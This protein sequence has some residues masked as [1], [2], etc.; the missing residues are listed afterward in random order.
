MVIPRQTGA[1]TAY[2]VSEIA[3]LTISNQQIDQLPLSP[4]RV[5][6]YGQYSKQL[7]MQA[8]IDVENFIRDDLLKVIAIDWD[9]LILNGSGAGSE[10]LGIM[11]TPGVGSLAFGAAA[12]YAN[13]VAF[14][15]FVATANADVGEMAYVTTPTAEGKL[16]SAAKLLT[17]A[18]TVA[19]TALWEG[20]FGS[21]SPDGIVAGFRAAST[22]QIPGNLMVFGVFS[23]VIHAMWG[24]YDVVVNPYSLDTNA[25]VRVTINTF[26]DVALRHPQ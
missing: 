16:R 26:G 18:T 25:E 5:G 11:Q 8:S 9:R 1:G 24:G 17:G 15:T 4:K 6:A 2:S 19:A 7:L 23:Q 20:P 10:P 14:K 12:T 13:L 21:D 3:G 22:N